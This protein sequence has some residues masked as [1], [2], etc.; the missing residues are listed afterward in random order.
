[1]A[2]ATKPEIMARVTALIPLRLNNVGFLG[3]RQYASSQEWNLSDRQLWRY[4]K[5]CDDLLAGHLERDAKRLVARHL[6]IRGHI[7]NLAL[8][9]GDLRTALAAAKDEALIHGIYAP[10]KF[11]NT[12]LSGEHPAVALSPEEREAMLAKLRERAAA[13][14]PPPTPQGFACDANGEPRP[15]NPS[16]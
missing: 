15:I 1:M 6:V 10:R 9:A 12:D 5:R 2:K 14:P 16:S 11:T 13:P 8:E 7:L 3:I 4:L